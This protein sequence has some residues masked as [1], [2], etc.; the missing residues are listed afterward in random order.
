M[1]FQ[2]HTNQCQGDV[3]HSALLFWTVLNKNTRASGHNSLF[4]K[5]ES[6]ATEIAMH[7]IAV[8]TPVE[9]KRKNVMFFWIRMDSTNGAANTNVSLRNMTALAV[10]TATAYR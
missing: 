3:P 6:T 7:G 9:K 2:I 4:Q 10:S 1:P 8:K 5:K